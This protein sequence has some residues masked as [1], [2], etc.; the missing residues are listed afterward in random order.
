MRSNILWKAG[1]FAAIFSLSALVAC[2]EEPE[3]EPTQDEIEA[4]WPETIEVEGLGTF[5]KVQRDT[6]LMGTDNGRDESP[7]H[8]VAFSS[9]YYI[10]AYEVTQAQ[11]KAVMGENPSDDELDGSIGD[12]LPV[13]NIRVADIDKFIAAIGELTGRTFDLPTE[14]QWEWA[15]MGGVKSEGYT[16]AGGDN[17]DDVAWYLGNNPAEIPHEV[18]QK[19]ANELGLYDMS[20]NVAEWCRD[21]YAAYPSAFKVDYVSTSGS[22]YVYRGGTFD[23]SIDNTDFFRVKARASSVQASYNIGFRLVMPEPL[24]TELLPKQ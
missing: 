3:K 8:E 4:R 18:G 14:A 22:K 16:Y 6:F 5:V 20:G 1:M 10:M 15:A 7:A 24:E 21:K 11:W 13:N 9:S 17:L 23:G 2:K 12:N 19:A